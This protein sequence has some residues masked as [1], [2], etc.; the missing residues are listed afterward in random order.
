MR[1]PKDESE[2]S[3]LSKPKGKSGAGDILPRYPK[4]GE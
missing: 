3:E 2:P 4:K 1:Q